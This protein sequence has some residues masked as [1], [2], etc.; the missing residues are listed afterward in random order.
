[1][2]RIKTGLD[3]ILIVGKSIFTR[4]DDFD[5]LNA[6]NWKLIVVDEF[7]EYKNHESN[8]H[9][10]LADLRDKAACPVIGMTGTLMQNNH[11]ELYYLIDMVR[12]GL[13]GDWS[14]F[15]MDISDPLKYARAKDAKA[16]CVSL[17]K[18]RQ[19]LLD[20]MLKPVYLVRKKEKE[21]DGKLKKKNEKV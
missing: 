11:K 3:F 13:F 19:K 2:D 17:G 4:A 5:A 15:R 16:E 9:M 1:M 21:L 20:R 14:A 7:H 12:P 8:A 18:D 6:V 10:R